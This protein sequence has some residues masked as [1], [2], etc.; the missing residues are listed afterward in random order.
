V[1]ILIV[2]FMP[3]GLAG[4]AVRGRVSGLRRIDAAI[5]PEAEGA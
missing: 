4:L 2:V 5:R 1:F 3:G